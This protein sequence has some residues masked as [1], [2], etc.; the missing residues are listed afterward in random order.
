MTEDFALSA[1]EKQ[2]PLWLALK[3]HFID[4]LD[5]A[6]QRNDALSLP[7]H[8]TAALRGKIACLKEMIRLGGDP[9]PPIE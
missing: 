7:D 8:E 4:R 5:V 9:P 6:R 3:A 2:S 1:A